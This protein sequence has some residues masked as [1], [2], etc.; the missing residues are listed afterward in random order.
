MTTT[1][2]DCDK[3]VVSSDTRWSAD[4]NLM[5]GNY[6]L[7]V[8]DTG[9][10][11]IACRLGGAIFC[12]GDGLIIEQ[13]KTWWMAEPFDPEALPNLKHNGKYKVSVVVASSD[14]D[15]IFDAGHKQFLMDPETKHIHALFTGSGSGFAGNTFQQCGCVKSAVTVA[16]VFDPYSGG[17]VKYCNIS[18]GE[19]N[20]QDETMSYNSIM[21]S[22][23]ERGTLMKF[24]GIYAA[25]SESVQTIALKDHP[26]HS[27]IVSKIQSGSVRAYAPM[28]GSEIDWND[29][30]IQRLKEAARKVAE[31]EKR[32]KS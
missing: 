18:T 8:D 9:F 27:E 20:L 11:K 16:K 3:N 26:Q 29:D 7:F 10:N 22:M 5:D 12:A 17:D 23:K 19:S 2:Y 14:G 24:T 32:K 25:N 4:L 13:L 21:E 30:R 15:I 1:A 6:I 28:G 31:I